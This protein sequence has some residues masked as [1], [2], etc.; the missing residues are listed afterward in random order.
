[1]DKILH[2]I[3]KETQGE[4]FTSFKYC[5]D[6]VAAPT[7]EYDNGESGYINLK[8]YAEDEHNPKP[9][10]MRNRA[11]ICMHGAPLFKYFLDGSRRVYK[12]DDIQYDKKVFPIVS[13]QISVACCS[14]ELNED[15]TFRSFRHIEEE[16]YPVLCLPVTANGEGI[17]HDIFFRNLR[18]KINSLPHLISAG[19]QIEKVLYYRT[20][21]EGRE[22]FENKGI[23]RIQDEMVDCEKKIVSS[24][25]SRRL[26]TQDSYLIKD[27]SIQYKPMKTGNFKELAHIRNNYRHVIGVSKKFNPNLMRDLKDQSSAGQIARLPLY[28][29]TPAFLWQPGEEWGNVNFAIWYVRLRDFKRSESP[30]AGIVKVE[31]MLMTGHEAE[32]GL[33]TDEIDT[34]TANLINERNPVCYGTDARWANHLYPVYMTECYCKNRFKSDY[35]FLNLF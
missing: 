32:Y 1:M 25:V 26:L 17:D 19:V 9:R 24:L 20:K 29:R 7:I 4:C 27:G 8:E 30:Y 13:G 28:H 22:T 18:D 15:Y 33:S 11:E 16:T 6:N 12:V 10:N 3:A 35:Y 2:F 31:K 34:I 21:L 23:A 14:R 5:Y